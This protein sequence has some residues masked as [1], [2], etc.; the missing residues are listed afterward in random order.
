MMMATVPAVAEKQTITI[1]Y[2][3]MKKWFVIKN[4]GG[5]DATLATVIGFTTKRDDDSK[6]GK[7]GSGLKYSI[8]YLLRNNIPFKLFVSN[9]EYEFG[10]EPIEGYH[11]GTIVKTDVITLNGERTGLG[12]DAGPDWE[13]WFVVR[14]IVQNAFDEK[15]FDY[16]FENDINPEE[17]Y[18]KWYLD[19]NVFREIIMKW[20]NYFSFDR[21]PLFSA[22]FPNDIFNHYDC[23]EVHA[24]QK[25]DPD[26]KEGRIY[27]QGF[28][29]GSVPTSK[30]D[31]Q[32]EK[33]D[34][35]EY[36][37]MRNRYDVEAG[38]SRAVIASID[39]NMVAQIFHDVDFNHDT[40]WHSFVYINVFS[41][42]FENFVKENAQSIKVNTSLLEEAVT[43]DAIYMPAD[44]IRVLAQQGWL[45]GIKAQG[46]MLIQDSKL[47]GTPAHNDAYS[48]IEKARDFFTAVGFGLHHDI[49]IKKLESTSKGDVLGLAQFDPEKIYLAEQLFINPEYD[50]AMLM[51][52]LIEEQEH[53]NSRS[54]DFSR[55]FQDAL[56]ARIYKLMQEQKKVLD[57][58]NND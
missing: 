45:A 6:V 44:F 49:S 15:G 27:Y 3:Y 19:F 36:R 22:R 58:Y 28:Y 2:N 31:Y 39:F 53:L 8:P 24:F 12:I 50:D 34:I 4:E 7:F 13:R 37:Q 21:V 47:S 46:D 40:I 35:N 30:Y 18:V 5:F 32:V 48:R 11:N 9:K 10:L 1:N 54:V 29:V 23:G 56:I 16:D 14:E 55:K 42:H 26:K 43:V 38:I 57:A 33:V 20:D 51:K 41:P 25:L 52:V 17:G